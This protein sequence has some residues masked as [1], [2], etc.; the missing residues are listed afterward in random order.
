MA[1][2]QSVSTSSYK[3]FVSHSFRERF[4]ATALAKE[5]RG[6]GA[7]AWLAE[8]DV[9]G[10]DPIKRRILEG[11]EACDE[12]IVLL[13]RY[14]LESQWVIFESGVICGQHKRLTPILNGIRP[15]EMPPMMDVRAIDIND[16]DGFW[17][18]LRDR[19]NDRE[20][21]DP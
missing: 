2:L 8:I 11:V 5:I 19:I 20:S 10:G 7:E 15:E 4:V 3:I 13:S 21:I 1:L 12:A 14:A 9:K 18:E 6:L 17:A 16:L